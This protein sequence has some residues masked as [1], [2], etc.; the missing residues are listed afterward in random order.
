MKSRTPVS[1]WRLRFKTLGLVC[2]SIALIGVDDR[3]QLTHPIRVGLLS[4]IYP[5][6]YLVSSPLHVADA[7]TEQLSAH[8][9]VYRLNRELRATVRRL[10]LQHQELRSLRQENK[11][12][13]QLLDAG[14]RLNKEFAAA[15]V[16]AESATPVRQTITIDR[17]QHHNA[18]RGQPVISTGGVVGHIS[19]LTPLSAQVTL[20]SDPDSAI[21]VAVQRSRA[22]GILA[23]TGSTDRVKLRYIPV[24]ATIRPGDSLV[25]SGLGGVYPKG[26]RVAKV[27][28]VRR[29]PHA[30]F[31]EVVASPTA[32]L[33]RLEHV[34]VLA[35][36]RP[37]G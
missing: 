19:T 36:Q 23:G 5:V 11:R 13:R 8:L 3:L 2:L 27:I 37:S 1:P 16:V 29:D 18:H 7:L 15:Q 25:T 6:Q 12:L 14:R 33:G 4:T 35:A 32:S 31:A 22:R 21:P 30:A 17:G 28:E 26:L 9:Q 10:R 34:L 24:T 20:L